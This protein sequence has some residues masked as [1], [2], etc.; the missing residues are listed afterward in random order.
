[1]EATNKADPNI[2]LFQIP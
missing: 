1:M 2:R